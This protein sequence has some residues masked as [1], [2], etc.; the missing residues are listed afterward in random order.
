MLRAYWSEWPKFRRVSFLIGGALMTIFAVAG[1]YFAIQRSAG[2]INSCG[3]LSILHPAACTIVNN[4]KQPTGLV[5]LLTR[6]ENLLE[7]IALI[8]VAASVGAEYTQGTLRNLLVREPGR[9][10]LLS[11][12]YLA[13]LTYVLIATTVALGL[14]AIVAVASG[15]SAGYDTSIWTTQNSLGQLASLWGNMLIA[16]TAYTVLGLLFSILFRSAAAAVGVSLGYALVV[17]GLIRALF[18]DASPWLLTTLTGSITGSTGSN[19]GNFSYGWSLVI[20]SAYA[21]AALIVT[22]ALFRRRDVTS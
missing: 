9:L 7:I 10:R 14:G 16:V 18:P 12:K 19:A 11:G 15:H 17:E 22:A 13:M 3:H 8:I 2:S 1:A 6:L 20:V 5:W 4:L 21:L